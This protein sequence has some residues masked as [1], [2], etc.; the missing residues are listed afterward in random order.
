MIGQCDCSQYFT[1]GHFEITL[2]LSGRGVLVAYIEIARFYKIY[3]L[4]NFQ[5]P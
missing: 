4:N 3:I 5:L 1:L 2:K